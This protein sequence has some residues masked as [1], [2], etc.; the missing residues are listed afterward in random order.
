MPQATETVD[1]TRSV[2][3]DSGAEIANNTLVMLTDTANRSIGL[4]TGT[5]VPLYGVTLGAIGDDEWGSVQ[6]SGIARCRAHGAL[7]TRGDLLMATTAGRVDTHTGTN[8]SA[9]T[10]ITEATAQDDIVEVELS[11]PGGVGS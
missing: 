8:A 7:A 9:G 5:T 2:W 11:G 6:I 3:N 10:L 1:R 4:P